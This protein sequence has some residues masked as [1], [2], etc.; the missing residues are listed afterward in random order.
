ME[1]RVELRQIRVVLAADEAR[2]HV[3]RGL[4]HAERHHVRGIEHQ[5]VG[6]VVE[7]LHVAADERSRAGRV[8]DPDGSVGVQE[9]VSVRPVNRGQ[10]LLC[11]QV[12]A[13]EVELAAVEQDGHGLD[14]S[15]QQLQSTS[16]FLAGQSIVDRT[17]AVLIRTL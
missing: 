15:R 13:N 5:Q 3:Q 12:V 2:E 1:G 7:L 8:H 10:E 9:L 17:V 6:Q 14:Q 4:G 16:A 11:A